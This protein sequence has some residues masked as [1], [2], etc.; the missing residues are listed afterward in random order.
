MTKT[1]VPSSHMENKP[2]LCNNQPVKGVKVKMPCYCSSY[3]F[4]HRPGSG[5]CVVGSSMVRFGTGAVVRACE[6]LCQACG[7]PSDTHEEDVGIGAYEFWGCPGNHVQWESFTDCCDS[8][9]VTNSIA[10][11]RL[12]KWYPPRNGDVK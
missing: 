4:P 6:D 3:A 1:L 9:L 2:P 5:K 12:F 10:N 11:K 8:E 7:Q